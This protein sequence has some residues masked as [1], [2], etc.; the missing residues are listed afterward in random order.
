[1]NTLKNNEKVPSV[2]SKNFGLAINVVFRPHPK[3]ARQDGNIEQ[4]TNCLKTR[5]FQISGYDIYKSNSYSRTNFKKIFKSEK[6]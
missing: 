4:L 3:N 5:P 2:A 6:A 1:M